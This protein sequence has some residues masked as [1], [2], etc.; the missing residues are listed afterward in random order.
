[1]KKRILAFLLCGL[2]VFS[3]LPVT[4]AADLFAVEARAVDISTL[5]GVYNSVPDKSEWG[6]YVDTSSLETCYNYAGIVLKSADS[7]SQQEIDACTADLKAA[8]ANLKFHTTAIALNKGTVSVKVGNSDTLRAV[9]SPTGAG[10]E[11]TWTSGDSSVVDVEKTGDVE[12]TVTVLKYSKNPITVTATSN[13]FSASCSVKTLNPLNGVQLSKSTVELY[14]D[15]T[16]TL[17]AT[18]VGVDTSAAPTGDVFYTWSSDNTTIAA[19]SD[20]GVISAI[21]PGTCNITVTVSNSD[22]KTFTAKCAVTVNKITKI[23]SF[24]P[25]TTTTS[26]V[27]S[28]TANKTETFKVGILPTNASIKTLTWKSSDKSVATVSD[29]SVNGSTASVKINAIAPGKTKITYTATDGSGKSGSFYV[30]VKP[31]VTSL[32]ISD[33]IKVIQPT[34]EG[35]KLTVTVTPEDAGNQVLSW[36]SSNP[37]ICQVD[38]YGV[39][40][41]VKVG[42]CTITARATD[43]TEKF[44]TS[45][46]RVAEKTSTVTLSKVN[47]T[48]NAGDSTTIK[49]TVKTTDGSTY[50]DVKWTTGD[51]SIAV[52]DENGKITA[53]GPGSVV[54]KATAYDSSYKSAICIVNVN[55]PVTGVSV[56]AKG[57]VPVGVTKTITPKITPSNASNPAVTFKSSN[58]AVAVV[59]ANGKV[60]GKKVGKAIIT[61]TTVDGGF[62]DTCEVSVVIAPEGISLNKKSASLKAGQ[63]LQLTA[64]IV[65][66]NTTNKTVTWTSSNT[67]V[68]TVSSKGLVTAV[69]GGTCTITAKTSS[70]SFTAKCTITVTQTTSGVTLDTSAFSIYTTGSKTL[71]ATVLPTTASNKSVTWTSDN[72]TIATVNSSGKVTGVKPGTAIITVKTVD[73]GHT[74]TCVVTVYKKIDVTGLTIDSSRLNM[75]KGDSTTI[76]ATISPSNASEKGITWTSSDTSVAKV[77]SKGVVTAVDTGTAVI[78]AVTKDGNYER[79]CKVTVI[80]PVT[81]VRLSKSSVKL[82]KGKS[83]TLRV[84]VLPSDATNKKVVWS[85]SDESVAK[86]SS[87]GVVTALKPGNTTVTVMSVDG[88]YSS[89]C[90]VTVYIAVTGIKLNATSIKLPKSQKRIITATV[91]PAD[92]ENTE[93][94]WS[95]SNKNVVTVNEAGQITGKAKGTA[96]VTATTVDG[97]LKASCIVEVVQLVTSVKLDYTSITIDAGKTKTVTATASPSTASDRSVKWTT[98]NKKVATVSSSGVIKAVGAGTATITAT[99]SDGNAKAYCKVKVNQPTTGVSVS[100]TKMNVNIGAIK[101]ITAT[102]KPADAT[103]PKVTW[104][105]SDESIATVDSNGV[106]KGLKAGKVTITVTTASGKFKAS[107]VVTVIRPVKS[108]KLNKTSIK[109]NV[110]RATTITPTISPSNASIKTVTWS[111]SNNDVAT[112]DSNGK[113]TAKAPGYAVITCKTKDGGFKATCEVLSIRPVSGV[114]LNKSSGKLAVGQTGSLKATVSPSNASNKNV[115]WSSS[116]TKIAKVSSSGVITALKPGKVTITVKT[117][118][119]GFTAKCVV[120]IISKVKGISLNHTVAK[121]YLGKSFTLKP[122]ITPSNATDKSIKW[123]SSD[124]SVATVDSKGYVVSKK[125]GTTTITAKTVDGGFTAK[126]VVT[127]KRAVTSIKLNKTS[128]TLDV[129]ESYTLKA[130][131]APSNATDKTVTWSSSNKNVVTVSSKGVIKAVG[132]GT[133]TITAKTENGLKATCKVTVY[134]PVTGIKIDKTTATVYAGEEIKI[135]ASAV[136]SNANVSTL[137]WS[138]SDKSVLT[139]SS[140]GTVKGVKAG[141]ATVTVKTAEGGF[142]AKCTVTV[143]QHVNSI[144]FDKSELIIINGKEADLKIT[145]LPVNATDKTFTVSSSDEQVVKVDE[146]GHLVSVGCGTAT[147]TVKSNENSKSDECIVQVVEPVTGIEISEN[148]RTMFVDDSFTLIA[149]VMPAEAYF[150]DVI[151][152]SSDS[153]VASVDENGVVTAKHSGEAVITAKTA[154]GGFTAECKVTALQRVKEIVLSHESITVNKGKTAVLTAAVLPEDSYN[155]NFTWS[156]DVDGI[157]EIADD[158]TVTGLKVGTVTVTVTTED[159]AKTDTC[160]V[161]VYEPVSELELDKSEATLYKGDELQLNAYVYPEDASD[162]KVLWS[163]NDEYVAVVDENGLVKVVGKGTAIITAT[164]NNNE[165]IAK[166]CVINALLHVEDIFTEKEEYLCYEGEVFSLGAAALPEGAENPALTYSS[167]DNAVAKVDEKGNVTAVS[168]GEAK[169]TVTSVENSEIKKTVTVKVKRAVT[170]VTL[171]K[172][173]YTIY[174]GESFTLAHTVSPE[175][176]DDKSVVWLSSNESAAVVDGG[177]VTAVAGGVAT[178]TVKTVDGEKTAECIVTVLEYPEDIIFGSDSYTVETNKTV[179]V[180]ATVL[181]E[182]ASD[183]TLLWRSEDDSIATV[184]EGVITGVKA[185]ETKIYAVTVSGQIERYVTVTVIQPPESIEIECDKTVLW[186]GETANATAVILPE[187]TTDKT[188]IWQSLNEDILTVNDGV[189]TAVGAG[190]AKVIA[191]SAISDVQG[192]TEIEVRQQ[193]TGI[194]LD[195]TEKIVNKESL[196]TLTATVLPENAYDKSVTWQTGDGEILAVSDS[197]EV[198]ALKTGEAEIYA[199]SSDETIKAVCKVKVIRFADAVELDKNE[200]VLEKGGE[201]QFTANILPEDTTEKKLTWESSD[202][203]TVSVDENGKITAL[204]GG[205]A[206]I[207]VSTETE[208][209]FAEC[210]VTVDVK[211]ESITLNY[212]EYTLYCGESFDIIADILPVDTTDKTIVWSSDN[213]GVASVEDGKVTAKEKGTA[214]ITATMKDSGVIAECAVTVN[215]HVSGV[216]IEPTKIITYIGKELA[217]DAAVY[218]EDATDKS[219][220]WASSDETVATVKDGTVTALRQGTTIITAESTDGGYIDYVLVSVYQGIESVDIEEESLMIEKN[221]SVTLTA[222]VGPDNADDKTLLWTSSDDTVATVENGTVTAKDKSGTVKIKATA[223]DNPQVYDECEIT[224]KEPV[225]AIDIDEHSIALRKGESHTLSAIILPDEATV[226]DVQWFSSNED[227]AVVDGGKVTAIAPGEAVITVK[228]VDS[229]LTAECSVKVYREIEQLTLS[230]ASITVNCKKTLQLEVSALP[231]NHDEEFTFE[232]SDNTILTVDKNGLVTAQN[233]A[234]SATVTVTSTVSGKTASFEIV[235][236]KSVEGV[237]LNITDDNLNAYTGKTDTLEYTVNPTDASNQQVVWSS[238][239][240]NIADISNG[241]VTYKGVGE[242]TFTVTTLDGSF[243][244]TFTVTV[245]QAPESITLNMSE[246]SL[247]AG[248]TAALSANVTPDTSYDTSVEWSSS[249]STIVKVD[250]NGNVEAVAKGSAVITAA[251][252]NGIKAICTVTV[253]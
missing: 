70:G 176:A 27:L 157:I 28:L 12:A 151:W 253:K 164:S 250:E 29:A 181:P 209:V 132:K 196:F 111:S 57:E 118:D 200:L 224:V 77:S 180:E 126:C 80:Q 35:E 3:S 177:T 59:D 64:T 219:L 226:K 236:L 85:S 150:R 79:S 195:I 213:D 73:G 152:T 66:S 19:V 5:Q 193:V 182:T 9:L 47:I 197:G 113:V 78:T 54:I 214:I 18:A 153:E 246:I 123:T 87:S 90:N 208:G 156:T 172:A 21:N 162:K 146:N 92:A 217:V 137:K 4:P 158:G 248:S 41:P 108:V 183:K 82:S 212:G 38:A 68:A 188:V 30:E 199:V 240:V 114:K 104:T 72:N 166:M 75:T 243:E 221:A 134:Q 242:V 229:S 237:T 204:K 168:K 198:T 63:T 174:K 46:V 93:V 50:S 71:K 178:I 206:V 22:N 43:G 16:H 203:D 14:Q 144:A 67:K 149:T 33:K 52:V 179:S 101:A 62:T 159:G 23:S 215:K 191:K 31:L 96:K 20:T 216:D 122:T 136:P 97:E 36:T 186:V 11:V 138:T 2:M 218:P 223:I 44:V 99:S 103:N 233:E 167:N 171:D 8:L 247:S 83:E 202:N 161:E 194:T 39:L 125:P 84:S 133:A 170:D 143:K 51:K 6:K 15:E 189:I 231:E 98:S 120:T 106:V 1:M 25:L 95:T 124:T 91:T 140:N 48:L 86:V 45:T 121:L 232:S 205:H 60:T 141:V 109:L 210:N 160:F 130:T 234:G 61:C 129:P 241:V 55:Q 252:V 220:I 7:L 69:A 89:S 117:V 190:T 116:D 88:G 13:G 222:K 112:V 81:G 53:K 228:S 40:F 74:A 107:C 249:D 147:I 244:D 245:K 37:E 139:V 175:S 115:K 105:S 58:T 135:G 201:Y 128:L 17:K 32:K 169:I 163:S 76:L 225:E 239:D 10:D 187:D 211:S 100:P 119:G 148:E 145:V 185:G 127:V 26:G 24:Q 49:A 102:V 155:K 173:E 251:T 165:E 65:P 131:L 42:V 56:P 230:A 154:D 34:S 227:V 110:G 142:T 238:S 94:I 235:V 207:K 184:N 192:E